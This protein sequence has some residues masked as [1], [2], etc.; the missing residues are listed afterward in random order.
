MP[1]LGES[2]PYTFA[3]SRTSLSWAKLLWQFFRIL[4]RQR[5]HATIRIY[6]KTSLSSST[7]STS[8]LSNDQD[9]TSFSSGT[10]VWQGHA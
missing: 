6:V 2:T 7:S 9:W 1:V 5:R 3:L 8:A 10:S 4:E